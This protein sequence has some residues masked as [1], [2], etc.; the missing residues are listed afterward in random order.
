MVPALGCGERGMGKLLLLIRHGLKQR[1]QIG[2][3]CRGAP[4]ESGKAFPLHWEH[5]PTSQKASEVAPYPPT[6]A[7]ISRS[8]WRGPRDAERSGRRLWLK[9]TGAERRGHHGDSVR[10]RD[11][12]AVRDA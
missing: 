1:G 7:P 3:H 5:T 8:T 9:P 6:K 10:E 4:T 2:V 12:R 11:E